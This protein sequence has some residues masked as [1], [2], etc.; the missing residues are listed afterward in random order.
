MFTND[1]N[2]YEDMVDEDRGGGGGSGLAFLLIIL[3]LLFL[4][5]AII[6]YLVYSLLRHFRQR[7]SVVTLFALTSFIILY[8]WWAFADYTEI[9]REYFSLSSFSDVPLLWD[10]ISYLIGPLV[11]MYLALGVLGGW[12]SAAVAAFQLRTNPTLREFKG[13][14]TH[15]FEYRR[16]PFE[17]FKRRKLINGLKNGSY[18][19]DEAAPIGLDEETDKIVERY[20]AEATQHTLITGGTGAGKT[21]SMLSM[22]KQNIEAQMPTIII[23]LKRSPDMAAKIAKWTKENDGN[24]HHFVNGSPESYDIP[25]SSGQS[26]YDPLLTGS[27]TSKADMLLGM[28][29][30]DTAAAVYKTSMQQLL[31]VLFLMISTVKEKR[32]QGEDICPNIDW[33]S[34]GVYEI[35]SAIKTE[36]FIEMLNECSQMEDN[37]RVAND[38]KEVHQI[39]SSSKNSNIAHAMGELQGQMRTIISSEYGEWMKTE[40]GSHNIDLYDISTTPGNVVLFSLNSDDEKAFARLVGSIIMSDITRVSAQRRNRGDNQLVNIYIDEF[41]VLVPDS[42]TDLLEK[43]RASAMGVTLAQQSLSQVMKS[44]SNGEAY[45]QSIL[46]TVSNFVFHSGSG[47]ETAERMSKILGKKRVEVLSMTRRQ[48]KF[49][50]SINWSKNRQAMVRSGFEERWIIDPSEFMNLKSPSRNNGY[51]SE[52][53]VIKKASADNDFISDTGGAGAKKVWM[54]PESEILNKHYSP[55][56]SEAQR[57]FN[58]RHKELTDS[59]LAFSDD[60]YHSNSDSLNIELQQHLSGSHEN[61]SQTITEDNE[62][63]FALNT[64]VSLLDLPKE[65]TLSEDDTDNA[66]AA[67]SD[68]G[69]TQLSDAEL[70]NNDDDWS[71]EALLSEEQE[72]EK[73]RRQ[74]RKKKEAT[75]DK[76]GDSSSKNGLPSLPDF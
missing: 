58:E 26:F 23:D 56:N 3:G 30:Y 28:R 54:I 66:D 65:T 6:G 21:I 31:Q 8:A 69:F 57:I 25:Y 34:G 16:S 35:A 74:P 15:N 73:P 63:M 47:Y 70:E 19:S 4:P 7:A 44:V 37:S 10:N 5:S 20:N 40:E 41:Q 2:L 9:M 42:V 76:K 18:R 68:E 71:I 49:L 11:I 14:W 75:K 43:A 45:L 12:I 46:D 39:L 22:I 60:S 51:K 61:K 38:A 72:V 48:D 29:E 13:R 59:E 64:E 33:Y 32:A 62:D 52:A 1:D 27:N 55:S 50:W 36:N 17:I 53:I 67:A 24:F